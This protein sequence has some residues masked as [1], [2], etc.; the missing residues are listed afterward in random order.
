MKTVWT[1]YDQIIFKVGRCMIAY[2]C[3]WSVYAVTYS[4]SPI[5]HTGGRMI[6]YDAYGSYGSYGLELADGV[7][8]VLSLWLG[9]AVQYDQVLSQMIAMVL[10]VLLQLHWFHPNVMNI[11]HPIFERKNSNRNR[12]F[13]LHNK[14]SAPSVRMNIPIRQNQSEA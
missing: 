4:P 6:A 3:V 13:E 2:D 10:S 9:K 12:V 14:Y 7:K 1:V 8:Y 11:S 5:I